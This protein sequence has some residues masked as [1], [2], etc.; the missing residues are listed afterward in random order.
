[1]NLIEQK[2]DKIRFFINH[3]WKQQGLLNDLTKWN[4]LC[5]SIDIIED[6][7]MAINSYFSLPN[8]DSNNGGYLFLYGLLQAFFLQQ[9]AIN[10]LSEALFGKP[11]NWKEFYPD[12]YHIREIRNDSIGHPTKRGKN[13]SFHFIARYSIS[14]AS[15]RLISFYP[16]NNISK[17]KLINI[18][19]LKNNQEN[20]V[21]KILDEIINYME[22]EYN[23]HKSKFTNAKLIDLIPITLNYSISKIYEGIYNNY[24]L[25]EQNFKEIKNTIDK[26]KKEINNRYG[27]ISSLQGINDIIRRIDYIIQKLDGWITNDQL[28]NNYDAEIFIDSLFDRFKDLDKILNEIDNEF[29]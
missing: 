6:A 11:I 10:H 28:L 4:K 24:P 2:T 17:F 8:F 5:V 22:K 25:T 9:D 29:K 21:I 26:L 14:N 19:E 27:N 1:M 23:D 20:T 7:Q 15:F 12:I 18:N 13:E 16:S 3:P